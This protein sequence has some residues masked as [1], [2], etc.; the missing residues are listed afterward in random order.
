MRYNNQAED[1]ALL[2]LDKKWAPNPIG[3][4]IL[5]HP[6]PVET[7]PLL[8]IN[9]VFERLARLER[10]GIAGLDFHRLTGLRVFAGAGAA[11]AL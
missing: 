2:P 4:P 8:R 10:N 6:P 11:V 3:V 7:V 9:A 1:D 5:Y